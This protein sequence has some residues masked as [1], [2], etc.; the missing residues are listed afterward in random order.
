MLLRVLALGLAWYAVEL[1]VVLA[2]AT[3]VDPGDALRAWL[4][5]LPWQLALFAGIALLLAL[6]VRVFAPA[7]RTLGWLA[8]GAA[9]FVFVG[10]RVVEGAFRTTTAIHAVAAAGALA[11]AIALLFAAAAA[12]GGLLPRAMRRA[13][14]A[15]MWVAISLLVIPFAR[16]AGASI[17]LG[18]LPVREWPGFVSSA[19]LLAA[20]IGAAAVL[21]A[22]ALRGRA[23]LALAICLATCVAAR[24]RAQE[25]APR[26]L[27]DIVYVVIDTLRDDYVGPQPG[28]ASLTPNL[29]AIAAEG[30][31]FRHA[32]SSANLTRYAM[33][34][35][36]ASTTER[37]VGMPLAPAARTLPVFLREAGYATAG[38]SANPFVSVHYGYGRGFDHFADPSDAPRFLV[39]S[40][41]QL[42]LGIDR[43]GLAYRLGLVGSDLYYEPADRLFARGARLFGAASRPAFL[44]LHAMDVHGPYLPPLDLLPS[45][46]RPSDYLAYSEYLRIPRDEVASAAFAP[47]LANARARYAGGVRRAD[48][49][50]GRL[51]AQLEAS[52]RWDEALVWITADH[53]E[54]FGEHGFTGHGVA[55]LAPPLIQVPLLLK[56]PRSWSEPPRVIDEPVSPIDVLPTTLALL[57]R[58]VP[59]DC[60]GAPLDAAVR[61]TAPPPARDLIAWYPAADGEH[62]AALRGS[63]QLALRIAPDGVRDRQL[64]DLATDPGTLRDVSSAHADLAAA[65]EAAV[66]AHR[67][68]EARLALVPMRGGE[69]DP[70]T[71]ERL[72]A[73]GYVDDPGRMSA[74]LYACVG[75]P[76]ISRAFPGPGPSEEWQCFKEP[77]EVPM[78]AS[79]PAR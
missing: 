38:V 42:A 18:E 13:W 37:V 74:P 57:G 67:A 47:V 7:A 4:S 26:P 46:Y 36:L 32:Y 34:G 73:L 48:A 68:R 23:A 65:L 71:R 39:G 49:A 40:L 30:V 61:G 21:L 1:V 55:S 60:F 45:D 72:R 43:H 31:R 58:P 8:I 54:A 77:A 79:G 69:V 75:T 17:A 28:A 24:G 66:D 11:V 62:Y 5:L 70:A 2:T 44:Y 52:G 64:Y 50:I 53:G 56:L 22:A 33:P 20:G 19:S 12:C 3:A 10:S 25:V 41:L 51:R 63:W 14:P 59:P 16:S 29:D 15:A 27:P 76:P 6:V 78:A 35:L 9:T